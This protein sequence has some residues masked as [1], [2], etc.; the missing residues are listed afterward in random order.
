[1]T[2]QIKKQMT[3]KV[4]KG[5]KIQKPENE[6]YCFVPNIPSIWSN[7]AIYCVKLLTKIWGL[8]KEGR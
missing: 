4:A 8:L 5:P 7:V 1:M 3:E 6:Y 2:E